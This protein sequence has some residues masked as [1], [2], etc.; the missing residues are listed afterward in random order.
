[1]CV[2]TLPIDNIP[3]SY[4]HM[5]LPFSRQSMSHIHIPI[6]IMKSFQYTMSHIHMST[7][8]VH[9]ST[10]VSRSPS[11]HDSICLAAVSLLSVV[12]IRLLS[13]CCVCAHSPNT[14]CPIF[15]C[16]HAFPTLAAANVPYSH[17]HMPYEL[18]SVHN[19]P[20]S[21]VHMHFPLTQRQTVEDKA[22]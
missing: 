9:I 13:C 3:C 1:V 8:H 22:W 14:Q 16:P 18:R 15:T 5:R 7:S 21:H 19:I 12:S 6:C 17:S 10:C 2:H 20:Y 4:F 11:S